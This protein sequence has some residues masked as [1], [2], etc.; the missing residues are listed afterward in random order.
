MEMSSR[1]VWSPRSSVLSRHALFHTRDVDEARSCGARVFCDHRLSQLDARRPLDTRIYYRQLKGI[2]LGRMSYGGRVSIDPGRL[3]SFVLV[4]MPLRGEERIVSRCGTLVSTPRT[5]SVISPDLPV[6]MHHEDDTE[7][8]FIRIERELIQRHCLQHLGHE[9]RV[10]L[11]FDVG[12]ALDGEAGQRWLRLVE[13]FYAELDRDVAPAETVFGSPLVT[14][15]AEQMLIT[16][17]LTCQPHNYSE[18]LRREAPSIAPAFVRRIERY[19]EEHAHE[20]LT[21]VDLAEHAGVSSRSLFAGFRRFRDT[22]P[23]Q[24]LKEV[25]LRRVR[26]ELQQAAPGETTVTGVA[27]RWG[28]GHLSHFATDYKRRFGE[29]PSETLA[30]G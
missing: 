4:Q 13:W 12:M 7:K 3:E 21:I 24:H 8:L 15:Q 11:E 5:A 1:A 26:E 25:R 27:L 9:M 23:M 28:F 18:K 14:A 16:M 2:G 22:T 30:R 20:P 19:I 10:P 29:T 6:V 17:L